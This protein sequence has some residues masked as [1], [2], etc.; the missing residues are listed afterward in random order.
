M[1]YV[2]LFVAEGDDWVDLG[3]AA[4]GEEGGEGG[5]E[6]E[7]DGHGNIGEGVVGSDGV[8]L[9]FKEAGEGEGCDDAD[10]EAGEGEGHA[11]AEDHVA[12]AGNGC[13]EGHAD[14]DFVGA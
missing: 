6:E 4:G 7:E 1:P 5:D 14:A 13:A 2:S 11:L 10:G 9:S 3:G 8:K 12:D